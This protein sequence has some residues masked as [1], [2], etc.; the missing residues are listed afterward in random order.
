MCKDYCEEL[1][2]REKD[3]HD[4]DL[5]LCVYCLLT[6][7]DARALELFGCL[8]QPDGRPD[9]LARLEDSLA[10]H[11]AQ[12][13]ILRE[14]YR[15]LLARHEPLCDAY[16]D[17]LKR[18]PGHAV[19]IEAQAAKLRERIAM[20]DEE[21]AKIPGL[22]AEI[23]ALIKER[24]ALLA[25]KDALF[26]ER[27]A[28][29]MAIDEDR[30]RRIAEL[31]E[32]KAAVDLE[33]RRLEEN[34]ARIREQYETMRIE[35]RALGD[36]RA[37]LRRDLKEREERTRQVHDR[38]QRLENAGIETGQE[39]RAAWRMAMVDRLQPS[40]LVEDDKKKVDAY[41]RL[42]REVKELKKGCV[43]MRDKH[44]LAEKRVHELAE[45]LDR[46]RQASALA[47]LDTIEL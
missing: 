36:R 2:K 13:A 40:E 11:D 9:E 32:K 35:M 29:A 10:D 18:M 37:E 28:A 46:M 39:A 8:M 20:L 4:H 45:Q 41:E 3:H 24:D 16:K 26:R 6:G 38:L 31:S 5:L 43:K 14:Q 42:R 7:D 34:C 44:G 15:H 47:A 30:R 21:I 17:L 27:A 23:E 12:V 25:E 1:L 33:K 19:D 22:Q